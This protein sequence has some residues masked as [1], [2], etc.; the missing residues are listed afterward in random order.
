MKTKSK[1]LAV[2]LL[3]GGTMFAQTRLSIGVNVGGY[4]PRA[5]AAP[6]YAY[7]PPCPGPGYL[8]VDGYWTPQG[9]RNVWIQGFWRAPVVVHAPVYRSYRGFDRGRS[10]F[11][12]D[13][14]RRDHD[15]HDDR[16]RGFSN[17]FRR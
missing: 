8:W 2:A 14:D 12:R 7:Q 6:A 9:G 3:A 5:Y 4:G 1:L 13:Y 16:G 10:D 11:R 17:S 15:R